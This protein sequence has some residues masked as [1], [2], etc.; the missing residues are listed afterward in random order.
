MG[1]PAQGDDER[2]RDRFQMVATQIRGRGIDD[3]AVLRAMEAVPR[4]RFVPADYQNQAYADTPLPLP[5]GQTISQPYVVAY[6]IQALQLGPDDHVLEIGAGSG[7]VAALL[8]QIAA[9]VFAMERE[10]VLVDYARERLARLGVTNVQLL[11]GDG[12]RGWPEHAPYDGIVVSAGGPG[13]PA[14][15]KEQLAEG[16]RLVMPV[17]R[18]RQSQDLLRLTRVAPDAY[19][20]EDLGPVRFVPLLGEEGWD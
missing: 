3:P 15:L 12:T 20:R 10:A 2:R 9:A 7:Y 18:R 17:G 6:M 16:G 19:M 8:G 11:H 13:V 5:R 1:V 4:H 14:S